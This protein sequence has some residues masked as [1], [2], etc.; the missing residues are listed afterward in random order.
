MVLMEHG[1]FKPTSFAGTGATGVLANRGRGVVEIWKLT[2]V[3]LENESFH[4]P[5]TIRNL[6]VLKSMFKSIFPYQAGDSMLCVVGIQNL[7]ESKQEPKLQL[8]L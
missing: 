6:L 5:T 1:I 8:W 3:D 4:S 2:I 7:F